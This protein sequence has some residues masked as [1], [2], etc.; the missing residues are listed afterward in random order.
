MK[1][2]DEQNQLVQQALVELTRGIDG[3]WITNQ[4]E[5][6]LIAFLKANGVKDIQ[7]HMD[8]LRAQWVI[9]SVQQDLAIITVRPGSIPFQEKLD[10]DEALERLHDRGVTDAI[11]QV[12]SNLANAD[13]SEEQ[14]QAELTTSILIMADEA[15]LNSAVKQGL[16]I[17][18]EQ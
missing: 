5:Q 7:T 3:E 14:M 12:W 15:N 8:N 16:G 10:T 4:K 13:P 11:I 18:T 6:E 9:E 2:D 17:H 1:E